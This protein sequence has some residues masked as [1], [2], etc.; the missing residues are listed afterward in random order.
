M[1]PG[2]A[3]QAA[4]DPLPLKAGQDQQFGDRAEIV[5]VRQ[6]PQASN[7][8]RSLVCSDIARPA[9]CLLCFVRVILSRPDAVRQRKKGLHIQRAVIYLIFH[10][11]PLTVCIHSG[12]LSPG[13]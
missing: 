3:Q 7:Q 1:L 13:L 11:I 4:A 5:S 10:D 12:N 9:Q 6:D 2:K 8:P